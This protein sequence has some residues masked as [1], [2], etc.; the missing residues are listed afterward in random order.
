[1]LSLS[2]FWTSLYPGWRPSYG[3]ANHVRSGCFDAKIP[4]SARTPKCWFK[5]EK[6]PTLG[7]I[8][9]RRSFHILSVPVAS[10]HGSLWNLNFYKQDWCQFPNNAGYLLKPG[11][12]SRH[13]STRL[14]I[15][16]FRALTSCASDIFANSLKFYC[17]YDHREFPHFKQAVR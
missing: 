12:Q 6:A 17:S 8:S 4:E 2:T 7:Y 3:R 14:C 16:R 9:F 10:K 5:C 15:L 1:M 11:K 13:V